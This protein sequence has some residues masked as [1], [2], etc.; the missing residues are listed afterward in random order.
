MANNIEIAKQLKKLQEELN[1]LVEEQTKSLRS[2]LEI[3]K[4]IAEALGQASSYSQNSV[5]SI[6]KTQEALEEAAESAAKLNSRDIGAVMAE[7]LEMA[8]EE[9]IELVAVLKQAVKTMPGFGTFVEIWEGFAAGITGSV[10]ALRLFGSFTL[11]TIQWLGQL[12]VSI[13]TFPFE[14]LSIFTRYASSGGGGN[15]LRQALEDIRK[16]FGDLRK[17][18]A[19]AIID[20][21]R[22]MKGELAN[23]GL[24]VW[25]TF[26]RL[27]ERLKT[28]AEYAR[29]MGNVFANVARQFVKNGEVVAA[30]IKGLHLTEAGQKALAIRA[31]ALGQDLSE[32]SRQIANYSIQLADEFG[33]SAAQVSEDIGEMMADFEHFG[34]LAP[35]TLAQISIYARRLGVEIKALQGTIDRFDNFE[36]AAK[37]AAQLTQAFG[38]QIDAL[39]MLK[40]QDPAERTE[41]LRKAFFAAGRSI[42]NM[43]RQERALLAQQT[44]LEASSLDLIFSAKNQA[45][46][47]DQVKK[48]AEGAR[49]SQLT[50]A[51]ALQKLAGAIE[52]L[53]RSGSMGSGG[54]FERFFQ[55]FERGIMR[56][57]EFRRLMANIRIALRETFYAGI[58]VG[59]M[60]FDLFPGVKGLFKAFG[61][62][63]DRN[64]FRTM[65]KS[66]NEIFRD[67]FASLTSTSGRD[68]FKNLME[69]LKTMF[70]NYFNASTPAG[71][72]ILDNLKRFSKTAVILISGFIREA[73]AGITSG[74]TFIGDLLSGRK[75]LSGFVAAGEG[76]FGFI[77]NLL[78][79]IIE[80][81]QEAWPPIVD[82]LIRLW[83]E[84]IWPRV[85]NFLV[86]NAGTIALFLFGPATA[87]ALFRGVAGA[88]GGIFT[89]GL[90]TGLMTAISDFTTSSSAKSAISK[91]FNS[92]FGVG[93][94]SIAAAAESAAATGPAAK[95]A[96]AA[97]AAGANASAIPSMLQVA[98][99]MAI[100]IVAIIGAIWSIAEIMKGRGFTIEQMLTSAAIVAI[101]G[102]V[103]MEV[104]GA[105]GIISVAG[106]MIQANAPGAIVG[107]VALG[108]FTTALGIGLVAMVYA[109]SKFSQQELINATTAMSAGAAFFVAAAA[110]LGIATAVGAAFLATGGIGIAAA[111]AGLVAM[112]AVISG[113]VEA[114]KLVISE[115]KNL[116]IPNDLERKFNIFSQ[117]LTAITTFGEYIAN[118]AESTSHGSLWGWITGS[119]ADDQINV[120][121][122]LSQTISE[123]GTT[124]TNLV[125]NILDQVSN[126]SAAPEEIQRAQLFGTIMSTLGSVMQGLQ[127]PSELF[128]SGGLLA[129]IIGTDL[130]AN[131]SNYSIFIEN[132]GTS[133][134]NLF[135]RIVNVFSG[136]LSDTKFSPDSLKNLESIGNIFQV[137]GTFGRSMI[138][139]VSSNF[140]HL[141]GDTLSQIISEIS[142]VVNNLLS[143]LFTGR[144]GGLISSLRNLI[145]NLVSQMSGISEQDANRINALSPVL[146]K[147]FEAIASIGVT[148]GELSRTVQDIPAEARGEALGTINA[149]IGRMVYGIRDLATGVISELGTI[150]RGIST[151]EIS[152]LKSG[153]NAFAGAIDAIVQLPG[154]V[155]TLFETLTEG[156]NLEYGSMM[157]RLGS[158]ISLFYDRG[159]GNASLPEFFRV[160]GGA[161]TNLPNITGNPGRKLEQL[162]KSLTN[163]SEIVSLPFSEIATNIENNA[164]FL[165][166]EAF[167]QIGTNLSEMINQVNSIATQLGSIEPVNI[168]T[169]LKALAGRLG[170]GDSEE[171]TIKN[172]DFNIDV[173]VNVTIDAQE[174]ERVLIER[175][176]SR[177]MSTKGG[178]GR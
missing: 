33:Q 56:S 112:G 27:A 26:G 84:E 145:S 36:D 103:L 123:M 121:N 131:F 10:N 13:L 19:R 9:G 165:K 101:A 155:K 117:A 70:W 118:V 77:L 39:E 63:F 149:I 111:V 102:V 137:L 28:I 51:E 54:F 21:A 92:L 1:A 175:P 60:F 37:S 66:L 76:A 178:S 17:S 82:A 3:T 124:L 143:G 170:L 94:S 47:Y 150:F 104:A 44:G 15:E 50:Q 129:N 130:A 41:M 89:K 46:T 62:L 55:G 75:S 169:N 166:S 80:A 34:G 120:L 59:R 2:Q 40:A 85:K 132:M 154:A 6:Q 113:M 99:V 146:S 90:T 22:G 86:D 88:V 152:A 57:Y 115:V 127:A 97:V 119:G 53:V 110:V 122:E 65:L 14:L 48:R 153:A 128:S 68:S 38:L 24:S 73:A 29:N 141:K 163:I 107:L 140:S 151:T 58:R 18:S 125:Q 64:R 160:V 30:Y 138:L 69:R 157:A 4:Q 142:G 176:N 171:I 61:D 148:V 5:D 159:A 25:R 67:F 172:R 109:L 147:A 108:I 174:L 134:G 81:I 164:E 135:E 114:T 45:L 42:E 83:N 177:I 7:S 173:T 91:G 136:T 98:T 16:E 87:S 74:I 32:V 162:S 106:Q 23:T 79:P 35:Q 12:A 72:E 116:N 49:K 11:N 100:G 71:R 167:I 105:I 20:I 93:S 8:N 158:M 168:N 161:L 139:L 31:Y 43:T 156:G 95:A 96:N 78:Q 126:L 52:R 133:L 144:D